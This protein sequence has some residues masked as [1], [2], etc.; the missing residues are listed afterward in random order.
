MRLIKSAAI[1]LAAVSVIL[2]GCSN[3]VK[4]SRKKNDNNNQ[5]TSQAE[6]MTYPELD[7]DEY[8]NDNSE[9]II[10]VK[11]ADE[12][13]DTITGA[14]AVKMMNDRGFTQS[15]LKYYFNVSGDYLGECE[16]TESTDV[17]APVYQTYYI[18]E[19]EEIW[20]IYV[21]GSSVTAFP[22]SFNGTSEDGT[23]LILSETEEL[24]SYFDN[25]NTY[26]VTIPKKS[27]V[28]VAVVDE[29]NA[30]AFEKYTVKELE[31]L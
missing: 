26:Y 11:K 7:A 2:T 9:K 18:T 10:D 17:K 22:L 30:K 31:K 6:T 13:A 27:V 25:S 16:A 21:S 20:M 8:Y 23:E 15:P 24:V 5:I 29:I 28:K 12:Y 19:N 3:S 1:L 4:K 14:E